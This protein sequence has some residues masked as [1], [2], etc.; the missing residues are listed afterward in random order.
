MGKVELLNDQRAM[1]EWANSLI[2]MNDLLWFQSFSEGK[3][4][5][6]DVISHFITWDRF[7]LEH[8]IPYIRKGLPFPKL[9]INAEK[10]NK[11]ASIYARSGIRK[12]NLINEYLH[13]K[14]LVVD[15]L[16]EL[17]DEVYNSVIKL[18][19]GEKTVIAYFESHI[20]HDI[21]HK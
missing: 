3:W 19:Q 11:D 12:E 4:G 9:D 2:E 10:M 14:G 8:R 17:P 6:A 20:Q 18:G 5:T 1:L 16:E 21:K 7:F 15:H 13:T